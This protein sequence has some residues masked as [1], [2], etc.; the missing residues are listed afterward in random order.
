METDLVYEI[1]DGSVIFEADVH[2]IHLLL[3]ILFSL[4]TK[5]VLQKVGVKT[6]VSRVDQKLF[7][8]VV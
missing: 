7:E 2:E 1:E 8:S 6:L 4:H 5:R 3:F